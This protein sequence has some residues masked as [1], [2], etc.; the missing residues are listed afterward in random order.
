MARHIPLLRI[1]LSSRVPAYEQIS[2]ELRALLVSGELLP[3]NP[4]PTVRQ[5]AM[6]LGVH[7]N[8]VAQAYR[9]LA[10]E[11]WLE[12]RRGRGARVVDRKASRANDGARDR[13]SRE[14][15]RLL[16]QSDCRWRALGKRVPE[17]AGRAACEI[18]RAHPR[19]K[20]TLD[21]LQLGR[22]QCHCFLCAIREGTLKW[23]RLT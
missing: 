2:G 15:N 19:Q 3:G 6:D 4:L 16:A 22:R 21:E 20:E 1:D 10:E 23:P 17:R 11:G 12:L 7:F 9:A 5:L 13:F 18:F 8:T 14:L